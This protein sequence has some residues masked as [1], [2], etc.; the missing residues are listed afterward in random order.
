[1]GPP[2]STMTSPQLNTSAMTLLPTKV[3]CWDT[4][5]KISTYKF[6]DDTIK[7]IYNNGQH[8]NA[9]EKSRKV[10]TANQLL[11]LATRNLED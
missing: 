10:K 7:P 9:I 4:V 8:T 6:R 2:Y 3:T 11:D 1:M 5:V